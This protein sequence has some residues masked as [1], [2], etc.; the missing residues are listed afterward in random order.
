M[1]NTT[2]ASGEDSELPQQQRTIHIHP[3]TGEFSCSVKHE[4]GAKRNFKLFARRRNTLPYVG[5][6]ATHHNFKDDNLI[7]NVALSLVNVNM[8]EA[9]LA[10]KS[11]AFIKG[12][13]TFM[14]RER[15]TVEDERR[16]FPKVLMMPSKSPA[17][18]ARMCSSTTRSRA[19]IWVWFNVAGI[20]SS[21]LS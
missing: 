18:S 6:F 4:D 12:T 21:F 7:T 20:S 16:P 17:F 11:E 13:N 8:G 5:V 10:S 19:S 2:A 14:S 3:F 9:A 1:S 15:V